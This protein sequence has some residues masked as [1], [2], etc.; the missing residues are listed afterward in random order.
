MPTQSLKSINDLLIIYKAC[1]LVS[2]GMWHC[3]LVTCVLCYQTARSHMPKISSVHSECHCRCG[4]FVEEVHL[5][6]LGQ[7]CS[8]EISIVCMNIQFGG[9]SPIRWSRGSGECVFWATGTA[10]HLFCLT[11][12]ICLD[13]APACCMC[14]SSTMNEPTGSGSWQSSDRIMTLCIH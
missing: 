13:P 14:C 5:K 12:V 2:S 9:V 11:S 4:M 3:W 1:N 10:P 6:V 7:P 8:T